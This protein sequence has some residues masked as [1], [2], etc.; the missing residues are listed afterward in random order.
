MILLMNIIISVVGYVGILAAGKL[1]RQ[2]EKLGMKNHFIILG[3]K[4]VFISAIVTLFCFNTEKNTHAL[5]ILTG[6]LNLIVF[7]FIEAFVTQKKMIN[8]S[9]LNV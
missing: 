3:I 1:S 4:V 7:H 8:N 5:L 6:L 9:N 2:G